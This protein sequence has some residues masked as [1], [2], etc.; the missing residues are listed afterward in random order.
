ME[1]HDLRHVIIGGVAGGA[2]AAARLRRR[3]EKSVIVLLERGEHV[4]FANCG[5]PYHIGGVIP[6]RERLFVMT[7]ESF[8]ETLNVD[9]RNFSEAVEID[10]SRKIVTVK[11]ILTQETY[12]L[13]YD[14]LLLSPGAEPLRP[15]LEGID[16]P[17][18][19]SLRSVADMDRI[20]ANL[21]QGS[22]R[23]AVVLGG[24]FIGLEM[25]ENLRERGLA[26]ELVEAQDQVLAPLDFEMAAM[27]HQHLHDK[28]VA[29]HLKDPVTGFVPGE[30]LTVKLQ[31]G[32]AIATDLAIHSL[33]VRPDSTLARKS[34]IEVDERGYIVVDKHLRTNLPDIWAVGDAIVS[35]SPLTGKPL[36]IPL[37][38][39]ANKQGRIAADNM[40]GSARVWKGAL[41]TSI[42]KIFS[43]TAASTGL[44]EKA[45][46]REGIP[47]RS[48]VV[49][50]HSHA[51]YYPGSQSY[52]LK[53]VWNPETLEVL[54]AQAIGT[55]GVDKRID[56]IAGMLGMGARLEDLAEY[57]HCYAPPYA[58]AKDG[59]NYAAF[60]AINVMD[61]LTETVS[62]QEFR[63]KLSGD[64]LLLDVR[65]PEEFALGHMDGAR[66]L[67]HTRLREEIAGLDASKAVLVYCGVGLRG[68]LAE[69]ILRENGFADVCNLSGGYQTWKH[70]LRSLEQPDSFR[71][72]DG[73][74][75]PLE[76][77]ATGTPE[78]N[79][80][81]EIEVDACGLQC[82][83]PILALKQ[84]MDR[85]SVGSLLTV[86][87]TDPGFAKDVRSWSH[88]TGNTLV[89]TREEKG[90]LVATLRKGT[91]QSISPVVSS[92]GNEL[93]AI[94]FSNDL[95][96][97]LAS[98]V[99]AN[100]ALA[101]GKQVTLFFT[102]WG[103]SVI[104]RK[105][106]SFVKKDFMGRMFD[107]ML[108]GH[109]GKL[110]LSRMNFAGLGASMMK[111]R[112]G[113]KDVD[114]LE[115]MIATAR[116]AGV[117]MVACQ[118]SMDLMGVHQEELLEGV[119]IGGVAAYLE[120]A[121]TSGINLFI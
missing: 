98:F 28:G 59:V 118:M 46:A 45:C 113:R 76:R 56:A 74:S 51:G 68:Y 52:S 73:G 2:T 84:A 38:G 75:N 35:R 114:H 49:H 87:A 33:G 85:L 103:L 101:S 39:P 26:V 96:R 107:F 48:V 16:D 62:W 67:P 63:R 3:E 108:P 5:L 102:F 41:G 7:P 70:A 34:G 121:T 115:T 110:G 15:L 120:A 36:P 32:R 82:P 17:R 27:V 4:S 117:R 8:R 64:V 50:P 99:I 31:S 30:R 77:P 94:V 97:A 92:S 37:A 93:T 116:K 65:T 22:T 61:H 80:V 57:E 79:N 19:L 54:G 11:H 81:P 1:R 58:S 23:H 42:A 109:P 10:A 72:M 78:V 112:M 83:G 29:L 44:S 53:L 9:V 119:E 25:A 86:R 104:R 88:M 71:Q 60:L 89:G 90:I 12:E 47:C 40:A 106:K 24:G 100:G 55:E 21:A 13:E 18:V 95:D 105:E 91:G 69:R 43:L 66:N 111:W 20:L 14:K 6:D